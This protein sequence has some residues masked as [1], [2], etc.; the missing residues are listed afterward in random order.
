M[1]E[2]ISRSRIG[3]YKV[4]ECQI[5]NDFEPRMRRLLLL[6]VLHRFDALCE[7]ADV[8]MIQAVLAGGGCL[9][10]I[11]VSICSLL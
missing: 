2:G 3:R 7:R 1:D 4:L 9:K 11:S 8:E 10:E 6:L 5:N